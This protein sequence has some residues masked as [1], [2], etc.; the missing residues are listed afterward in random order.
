MVLSLANK[1]RERLCQ[2]LCGKRLFN[3]DMNR[4]LDRRLIDT[5][6]LREIK[7]I[8]DREM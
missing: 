3:R 6:R 2:F 5:E 8:T 7:K 1:L 4:E